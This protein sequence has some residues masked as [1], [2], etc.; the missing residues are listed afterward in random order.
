MCDLDETELV[1]NYTNVLR[2]SNAVW[3]QPTKKKFELK[4]YG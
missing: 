1:L 3:I 2:C 4:P